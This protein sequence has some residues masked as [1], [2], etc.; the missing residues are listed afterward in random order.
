MD[1]SL[2][3]IQ[4]IENEYGKL[5]IIS[6]LFDNPEI[7]NTLYYIQ[8]LAD[9]FWTDRIYEFTVAPYEKTAK[10]VA[11]WWYDEE[12][13]KIFHMIKDL[14]LKVVF[15]TMHEMNGGRYPWSND[16]E[17]FKNARIRIRNISREEGLDQKNILFDFSVNHWDMP[18][19]W[20]PSQN[21]ILFEC[22]Q[23]S[24]PSRKNCPTFESYYPWEEYVDVVWVSFYNRGKANSNRLR[25]SPDQILYDSRR[26]TWERLK[27]FGKPL[28]IDEVWTSSIW[29][30]EAYSYQKTKEVY[31]ENNRENKESWLSQ[32]QD[33]LSRHPEIVAVIYFNVDYTQGYSWETFWEADRSIASFDASRF[34][35]GFSNLLGYS[36]QSLKQLFNTFWESP[37]MK[38]VIINEEPIM[39]DSELEDTVVLIDNVL[40]QKYSKKK[41]KSDLLKKITQIDFDDWNINESLKV[42]HQIYSN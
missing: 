20:T 11:E 29:Y 31:D 23:R 8:R 14:N 13:R 27:K 40:N 15:R 10:E 12:Y 25:L 26:N 9:T 32:L 4:R 41:E 28:F 38:E 34:Y 22:D 39:I 18:T 16:P 37:W 1:Y 3:E 2:E 5:P 24:H 19:K 35:R 6:Y 17:N 21:A 7:E 33:F 42:L 36:N 30:N